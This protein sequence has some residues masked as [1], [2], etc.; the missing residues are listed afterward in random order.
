M[1]EEMLSEEMLPVWSAAGLDTGC[2]ESKSVVHRRGLWHPTAQ[3]WLYRLLPRPDRSVLDDEAEMELLLQLRS[4]EKDNFPGCWDVS[5]AGHVSVGET[6]EQ[7]ALRELEEELGLGLQIR[8]LQFLFRMPYYGHY[9]NDLRD[10]EWQ[11]VYLARLPFGFDTSTL[12]LQQS[13]VSAVRWVSPAELS[14]EWADF[15]FGHGSGRNKTWQGYQVRGFAL[16]RHYPSEASPDGQRAPK[17]KITENY[18]WAEIQ[19]AFESLQIPVFAPTR[20][21]IL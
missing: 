8:D 17:S 5:I 15:A 20:S 2:F 16:H 9:E 19:Q 11:H 18:Y 10:C 21:G 14:S 13:E 3:I 12:R 7:G 4:P 6:V 1:S